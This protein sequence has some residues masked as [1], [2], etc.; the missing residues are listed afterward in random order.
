MRYNYTDTF[1]STL[2]LATEKARELGLPELTLDLLLWGILREGTSAAIK[3]LTDRELSPQT[4]LQLTEALL[5][6]QSEDELP[7]DDPTGTVL[8]SLEA[9]SAIARAAEICTILGDQAISPLHLLLSIFL[10]GMPT[11]LSG[12][13]N[14]G[15]YDIWA[16]PLIQR[17]DK[18]LKPGA[19][20]GEDTSPTG[21]TSV[22]IRPLQALEVS[23]KG[24]TPISLGE[25]LPPIQAFVRRA[26]GSID[27]EGDFLSHLF[28][29]AKRQA[30][31][32]ATTEEPR[33]GE[34]F[35]FGEYGVDLVAQLQ[36]QGQS[37][38]EGLEREA[39]IEQLLQVLLRYKACCPILIGEPKVGKTEVV[40]QLARLIIRGDRLPKAFPYKHILQV[41]FTRLFSGAQFMGGAEATIRGLMESL[42]LSPDVLLFVDDLHL[43]RSGGRSPGGE[44]LDTLFASLDLY[45]LRLIGTSTRG[46]YTQSLDDSSQMER[47]C[48]PVPVEPL[49][50]EQTLGILQQQCRQYEAH[51]GANL[52]PLLGRVLDLSE[53]YM[54][55]R[56]FPYK[57]LELLD[58]TGAV[59]LAHLNRSKTRGGRG[60]DQPTYTEADVDRALA[61][62]TALP[63][64]RISAEHELRALIELPQRLRDSVLGQ[65]RAVEAIARAIQR[66]RLGLRDSRRPIASMLF[67][68]P[69]GVGKTYL[70]KALAREVFGR[71]DAMVRI[72]MSEFSERFAVS[73][74]IGSPPGYI[75]YGEGGELTEPVRTRPY[76]LVL[77][78]EI[79]KA[80]PDTY[81]ILLQVF[82][83]GR[84]TDTEGNVVDFRNTIVVMTSNVGSR[85]AQAFARGVGFAGLTN[86]AERSE[87]ISRQALQR[88]FSPEFLNRLDEI[89]AF[90]PLSDEALVRIFELEL[91]Q[92]QERV[93]QQGYRVSISPEARRYLALRDLDRA[94]GARPLRRTL[95]HAVEDQLL[96]R[97]LDGSLGVGDSLLITLARNQSLRY[98]VQH[99]T[100]KAKSQT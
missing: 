91:A 23:A 88:T 54:P 74:L 67:L 87:R 66:S 48:Y 33:E 36:A 29:R 69:T 35:P 34:E 14:V 52:Q 89:I 98:V 15:N 46:G 43:L 1:R 85:Q 4:L 81:N 9:H 58:A 18:A 27:I 64:E 25:D 30:N 17:I 44:V 94:M 77:L 8:Y 86:E 96:D 42:R 26:E 53:R 49:T 5:R 97:I 72:D 21:G 40:R 84:L 55:T 62:L 65:D 3:F 57:A 93:S 47:V 20:V 56:P 11:V 68:G 13:A 73:R 92:L 7:Y 24:V 12:F 83:D 2:E 63:L 99:P 19:K 32:E 10:C 31:R 16:D 51:Y 59:V 76:C 78:D 38:L 60:A 37:A 95:Q 45:G 79:E 80:H 90:E 22:R 6:H 28:S 70:A 100:T 75:G 82:E 41:S 61:R 39:E 71:E 50:R